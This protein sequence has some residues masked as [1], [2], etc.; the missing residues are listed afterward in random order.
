MYKRQHEIINEATQECRGGELC[1]TC[2]PE[3]GRDESCIMNE[4]WISDIATR[5][6]TTIFCNE[7]LL[8]MEAY[9]EENYQ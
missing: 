6:K 4:G 7:C 9:L 8:D 5:I 3:T 2:N 1:K